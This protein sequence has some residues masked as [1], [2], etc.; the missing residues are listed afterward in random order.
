M[1]KY[2]FPPASMHYFCINIQDLDNG[3]LY[4][5]DFVERVRKAYRLFPVFL[6]AGMPESW[7]YVSRRAE[8]L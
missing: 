8:R 1:Y 5:E 2:T 4:W 3:S 7:I 6:F